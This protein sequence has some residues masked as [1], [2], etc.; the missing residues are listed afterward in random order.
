MSTGKLSA[1]FGYS[2]VESLFCGVSITEENFNAKGLLS[3]WRKGV[4]S[5]RGGGEYAS[6]NTS[7]GLKSRT[8]GLSWTKPHVND[9]PWTLGFDLQQN[10]KR[11]L[12]G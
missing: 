8:Y 3:C 5:L 1:M 2:S 7:F 6:I 9:T 12:F 4:C 11:V 10:T